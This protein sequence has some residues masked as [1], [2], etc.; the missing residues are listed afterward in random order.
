MKLNLDYILTESI[1]EIVEVL[2]DFPSAGRVKSRL[3]M[4]DDQNDVVD[5]AGSPWNVVVLECDGGLP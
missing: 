2:G 3:Q 1:I 5:A 4:T